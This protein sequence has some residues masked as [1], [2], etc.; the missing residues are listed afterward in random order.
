MNKSQSFPL[1]YRHSAQYLEMEES[2]FKQIE[3]VKPDDDF[4]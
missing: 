3:K 4:L 1:I 2:G